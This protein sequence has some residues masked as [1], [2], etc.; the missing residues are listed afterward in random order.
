MMRVALDHADNESGQIV[1]AV[2]I[3]ARHL[4]GFAADQST[5][6]VFAGFGQAF[7]HF[8]GDFRFEFAGRQV[9]HEKQRRC[10]LHGDVIDAVVHQ[11]RADGVMHLHLEGDFQLGANAVHARDQH[12]IEILRLVNS[13]QAAKPADFAEHAAGEGFVGE[14]LDPLLGAVGAVDI[15]AGVGVGDGRLFEGSWATGVSSVS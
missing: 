15:D 13:E 9:I 12:R 11:I 14:V 6:V 2:G 4:S 3:E 7:D 5:A 10:A 1:F 8:L